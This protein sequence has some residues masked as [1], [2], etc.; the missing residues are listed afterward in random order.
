MNLVFTGTD[1]KD[2][3]NFVVSQI[4]TSSNYTSKESRVWTKTSPQCYENFFVHS[5]L[6]RVE[7]LVILPENLMKGG[8]TDM[9]FVMGTKGGFFLESAMC[10]S[11]LQKKIFQILCRL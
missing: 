6:L 4:K 10:F 9:I 1:E 3:M 2:N 7:A 5:E 8:Q 11:N